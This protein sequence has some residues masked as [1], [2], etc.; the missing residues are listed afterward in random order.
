MVPTPLLSSRGQGGSLVRRLRRWGD[1]SYL[2]APVPCK[3]INELV[4]MGREI[5]TAILF[6]FVTVILR[7]QTIPHCASGHRRAPPIE[8]SGDPLE[9]L[10][11]L[12]WRFISR[13]YPLYCTTLV[14][15]CSEL[16]ALGRNY[17]T[18]FLSRADSAS[19][20]RF[21]QLAEKQKV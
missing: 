10:L 4:Y 18:Q 16:V 5:L 14:T 11:V 15:Q 1:K 9:I 19:Q 8:K 3:L 20:E 12:Y 13:K 2:R 21:V 6:K 7:A 17:V